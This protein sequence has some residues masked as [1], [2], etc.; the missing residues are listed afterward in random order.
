MSELTI[1][2]KSTAIARSERPKSELA[3]T[4]ARPLTTRRIQT[5]TNGT[6]KRIVNGEQIG[7]A[8]REITVIIVAM[9]PQ[10]SRV[11]Y[12]GKY[13]PNAKPTLPDCWSNLGDKP[14]AAAKNKQSATCEACPQN[15]KGSGDNGGRACRYQRRVA[16]LLEGDESGDTYQF[17]IP[18]KSLF[19]KGVGNAHPFESYTK[20]LLA[21]GE[22]PDTVVT[23]IAYDADA[24]TMQLVFSADRV[25]TDEEYLL[26]QQV[27]KDPATKR[28]TTLTVAQ[29]DGVTEQ[30]KG[31]VEK[32]AAKPTF[33]EEPDDEV[34][35]AQPVV[36]QPKKAETPAVAPDRSKAL[37]EVV[38]KWGSED[39]E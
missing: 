34:E 36:R 12:E 3:E 19:G 10:V 29:A 26:V 13:D 22:A 32:T 20:F 21:N 2:N 8:A 1:F 16:V 37:A 23:K 35:E 11:Y 9:L 5:G 4:L 28:L 25:L 6:F 27:Q 33:S 38:S 17:N 18:A 24:D 31:A 15:I 14:E 7:K 39:D 30:P